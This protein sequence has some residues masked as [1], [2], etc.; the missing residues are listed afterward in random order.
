[1]VPGAASRIL[2]TLQAFGFEWD[3]EPVYQSRRR[4]RYLAAL[5]RLQAAGKT[6][7]CSCSRA[8]LA[9]EERYPGHCRNVMSPSGTA[10]AT[11][12][13]VEPGRVQ[14]AD[15]IQG[16]FR[17]D[18]AAAVGD[19]AL[20]RRD[21][22]IG[23]LLAVV[24]D[25]AA[26]HVTHI[27][28]GADLLDNTPRQILL[29]RVLGLSPPCYA[30][31]P[32]LIEENGT[33]LAKSARSVRVRGDAARSGLLAIFTLLN[34]QPPTQLDAASLDEMWAWGFEHWDITRVPR[35]LTQ[36]LAAKLA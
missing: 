9:D 13:R 27:V 25:D 16:L 12:L 15:R 4:D 14:F 17:Q 6:F 33:K 1:M 34:L 32:V 7:E 11:R 3:E 18:V 19:L 29:Q 10:T 36:E 22:I 21:G 28:R 24:V 23:Y 35:R 5:E 30:H 31:L 20:R 8:R 2:R 26:Q